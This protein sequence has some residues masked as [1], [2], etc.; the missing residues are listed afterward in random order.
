MRIRLSDGGERL[1]SSPVVHGRMYDLRTHRLKLDIGPATTVRETSGGELMTN[2]TETKTKGAL[3]GVRVLD[4]GRYQAGPR[5]GLMFARLGADVIKVEALKGDESRTNGPR[6]RGQSAYWVQYNSGKRSLSINL[7][8]EEGK[9][10]LRDL[11]KVSDVLIQNFRPGTIAKMGFGYEDLK[12]LNKGIVMVNVSAYGQYG[13]FK[14]RVGFDT[15][16][17]A[18]SGLMSN[19]CIT[20]N[21]TTNWD[22]LSRHSCRRFRS[23]GGSPRTPSRIFRPRISSSICRALSSL[24]GASLKVTSFIASV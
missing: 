23:A 19:S 20:G 22:S 13:P 21:S 7:R 16:G 8:T 3:D 2:G 4:L 17:Q 10:V 5:C 11:V 12:K 18:M 1:S 15:I 9:E 14:D 24:S 6:V